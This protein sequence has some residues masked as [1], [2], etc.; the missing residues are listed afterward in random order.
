MNGQEQ[1]QV[2]GG[3]AGYG[4]VRRADGVV[5]VAGRDGDGRVWDLSGLGGPFGAG[6]LN[7]VLDEGEAAVGRMRGVVEG[8]EDGGAELEPSSFAS[9]RPVD[10]GDYVDFYACEHH[11]ANLG[12][13]F[14]PGVEPLLPNWRHL[15]VGYHGRTSTIVVSG[16]DIPRPS[17]LR[18]PR[19]DDGPGAP[20]SFGPSQRLDVEVE[21]GFVLGAGNERGRA[22]STA[23]AWDRIFGV[24]LVNDW[25]ARDIQAFE[26]QPLGPHLGKS[27]AT[28][29]SEW[30]VPLDLVP[31][32]PIAGTGVDLA[33]YLVDDAIGGFD[34]PLELAVDGDVVSRTNACHLSWS[35]AQMLAHMTVNG[36]S[37]RAGDLFASGTISGPE[38]G[39]FGSLI[40]L[41]LPFLA[42]GSVATITSPLLGCVSGKVT[43]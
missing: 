31:R 30:V 21:L 14:R 2:R 10:P 11:A 7:G 37:T 33:G 22:V 40:E 41:G 42:D 18:P 1:A 19:P 12:R 25:S 43:G 24:V 29:M 17:G 5:A 6:S 27:F 36:A 16:S 39:T 32:T 3:A 13:L 4:V 9:L 28:S 35:P 34:L 15:P 38:P 20:P 23:E 8:G 26:Y